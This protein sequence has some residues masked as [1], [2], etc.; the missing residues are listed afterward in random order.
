MI[1]HCKGNE[2]GQLNPPNHNDEFVEE[3][4][5]SFIYFCYCAE[6]KDTIMRRCNHRGPLDCYKNQQRG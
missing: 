1:Q 3:L 5:S 2:T 6:I 4:N